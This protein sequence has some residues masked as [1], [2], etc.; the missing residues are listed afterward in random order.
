MGDR[1]TFMHYMDSAVLI[2]R[3]DE[4]Q[5]FVGLSLSKA[6]MDHSRGGIYMTGE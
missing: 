2:N 5:K 1:Y 6:A 4:M 3:T